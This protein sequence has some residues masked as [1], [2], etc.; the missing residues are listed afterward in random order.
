MNDA[1]VRLLRSLLKRNIRQSSVPLSSA[2]LLDPIPDWMQGMTI[3]EV[4]L[5]R[6]YLGPQRIA[7]ALEGTGV[8]GDDLMGTLALE[9]RHLVVL[10]LRERWPNLI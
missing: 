3:Q 2:L 4:C 10:M 9:D 1:D 7:E 6:R 8:R 5:A